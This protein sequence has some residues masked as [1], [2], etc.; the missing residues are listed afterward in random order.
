MHVRHR[1][2]THD[3]TVPPDNVTS[4]HKK[5]C[6][7]R[8]ASEVHQHEM[9]LKWPQSLGQGPPR[10]PGGPCDATHISLN[11]SDDVTYLI[12]G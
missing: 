2:V 8:G 4:E 5:T 10:L 11:S 6:F 12:V 9:A 1:D 7:G 3:I